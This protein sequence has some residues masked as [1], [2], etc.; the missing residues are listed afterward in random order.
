[1]KSLPC[2]FV[3]LLASGLTACHKQ[4]PPTQADMNAAARQKAIEVRENADKETVAINEG[5]A[6]KAVAPDPAL[7]PAAVL[8]K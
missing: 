3:L 5:A 6:R 4:T 7:T 2:L 1:M 8:L